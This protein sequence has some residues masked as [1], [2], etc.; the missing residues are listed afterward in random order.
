[1]DLAELRLL[2]DRLQKVRADRLAADKIA[3]DLKS[4][5]DRL[6]NV[7]ID[8]M[9][10]ADL[11]SIGGKTVVVNRA[12]RQRAIATD[13]SK[14]YDY[15]KKHDAFDLLHRRVT[16]AAVKLRQEDGINVPGVTMMDYSHLS[17]GK[18]RS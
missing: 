12:P 2:A 8:E 18:P 15:I 5:E 1:M 14:L 7:L 17:Y 11:S 4:E 9:E 3:A 10:K 6:K 16:D 13:W